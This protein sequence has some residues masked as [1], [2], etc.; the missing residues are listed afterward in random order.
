MASLRDVVMLLAVYDICL[1]LA[2]IPTNASQLADDSSRFRTKK[3][4]DAHPQLK[5][6]PT[7]LPN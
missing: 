5:C 4:A 7:S 6:L 1:I 2:W 3:I